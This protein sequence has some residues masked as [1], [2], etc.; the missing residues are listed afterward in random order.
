MNGEPDTAVRFWK[1]ALE[2]DPGNQQIQKKI[3]HR[4]YFFE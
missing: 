1:M 2:L 4:A 3:K